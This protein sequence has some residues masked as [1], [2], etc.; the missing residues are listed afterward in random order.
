MEQNYKNHHKKAH[1]T[2]KRGKYIIQAY[3]QE[4]RKTSDK[5]YNLRPKG[6]R[7]IT[8]KKPLNLARKEK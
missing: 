3:P 6:A 2:I 5:Q 8:A 4:A 1:K 7:K